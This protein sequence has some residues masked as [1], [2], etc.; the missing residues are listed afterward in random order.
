MGHVGSP[1]IDF[2]DGLLP[3]RCRPATW[4]FD[5]AGRP[6]ALRWVVSQRR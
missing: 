1:L 2:D 6:V 4:P 5:E 3:A